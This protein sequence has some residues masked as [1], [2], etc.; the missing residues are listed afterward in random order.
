MNIVWIQIIKIAMLARRNCKPSLLGALYAICVFLFAIYQFHLPESLKLDKLHQYNAN[1]KHV[2]DEIVNT[3][4]K[5]VKHNINSGLYQNNTNREMED[6]DKRNVNDVMSQA[7]ING[8]TDYHQRIKENIKGTFIENIVDHAFDTTTQ[9]DVESTETDLDHEIPIASQGNI[10]NTHMDGIIRHSNHTMGL[11]SRII[12]KST[13]HETDI[14]RIETLK[15]KDWKLILLWR[16]N[17]HSAFWADSPEGR[18]FFTTRCPERRCEITRNRSRAAE[19]SVIVFFHVDKHPV[20]PEV[21]FPNQSYVH[22]L[23]ERPGPWHYTLV[24]YNGQINIT[25]CYRRDAD[26]SHHGVV[27]PK[28]WPAA[29]YV[30][31][32]PLYKK[33]KN[34]VWAV[35]NCNASSK[36]DLYAQEL[37]KYIDVDTYGKCGSLTCSSETGQTVFSCMESFEKTYKFYLSFENKICRDYVTEKFSRP[38]RYELIPIVLGGGDYNEEGPPHSYIDVQDYDSPKELAEYLNYLAENEEEYYKYFSWK[39]HYGMKGTNIE[40]VCPLCDIAHDAG[41]TWARPAR[42]DYYNWWFG[43]CDDNLVD[44]MREKGNW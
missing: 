31:R 25:W 37:A 21:R 17:R 1:A 27:E 6:T 36:R 9:P 16:I 34:V 42:E 3:S 11:T 33:T 29:D 35:S 44:R 20:W 14:K 43:G 4:R 40:G 39:A 10:Q 7:N 12:S 19:A 2:D 24:Q 8:D 18:N 28:R 41:N 26:V 15:Y 30:P 22:F 38:M 5:M 32:I 23:N 13:A